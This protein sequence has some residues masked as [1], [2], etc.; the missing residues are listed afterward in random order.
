M[1]V[2]AAS[3][4]DIDKYTIRLKVTAITEAKPKSIRTKPP[5]SLS[6][7]SVARE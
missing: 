6:A 1:K 5:S 2:R 7:K 3:W 4:I